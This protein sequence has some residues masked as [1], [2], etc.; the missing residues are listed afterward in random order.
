MFGL[1]VILF[2]SAAAAAASSDCREFLLCTGTS[3]RL[4]DRV[5]PKNFAIATQVSRVLPVRMILLGNPA[6]NL[7]STDALVHYLCLSAMLHVM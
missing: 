6:L 5:P 3:E 7:N 1:A 4:P 2:A